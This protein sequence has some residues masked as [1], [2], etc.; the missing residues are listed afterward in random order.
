ME[1]LLTISSDPDTMLSEFG[2]MQND[3]SSDS[4][5]FEDALDVPEALGFI[6]FCFW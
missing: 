6:M 1:M 5:I 4:D 2:A 3:S